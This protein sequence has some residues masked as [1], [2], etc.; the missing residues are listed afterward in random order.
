MAVRDRDFDP[1]DSIKTHENEKFGNTLNNKTGI[2]IIDTSKLDWG[3][4]Q[5]INVDARTERYEFFAKDKVTVT[6][7]IVIVYETSEKEFVESAERF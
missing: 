6:D 2:K 3:R 7:T 1:T 4:I 5:K